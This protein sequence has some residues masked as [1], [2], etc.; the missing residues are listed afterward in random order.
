MDD[1]FP[2]PTDL[3]SVIVPTYNAENSLDASVESLINQSY[4]NFEVIIQD[5]ASSDRT[6]II[7][8]QLA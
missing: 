4:P 5:D 7:G 1:S 8:S 6:E 3:V 2:N